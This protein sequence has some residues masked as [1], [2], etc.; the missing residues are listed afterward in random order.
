MRA[1]CYAYNTSCSTY[2]M[3]QLEFYQNLIHKIYDLNM[4]VDRQRQV[5][6]YE[7]KSNTIQKN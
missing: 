6:S 2:L 3:K 4:Y 5:G 7:R 1:N